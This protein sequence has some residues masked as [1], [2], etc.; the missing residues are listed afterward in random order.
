[1]KKLPSISKASHVNKM[2]FYFEVIIWFIHIYLLLTLL[3][4]VFTG[5][6]SCFP[7]KLFIWNS[8][9]NFL[10]IIVYIV[11]DRQTL[12]RFSYYL[13]TLLFVYIVCLLYLYIILIPQFENKW[14]QSGPTIVDFEGCLTPFLRN[15]LNPLPRI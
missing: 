8:N 2:N 11:H 6:Q 13:F 7:L 10:F 1:M 14:I 12:D 15:H 3:L 4:R 5:T 9:Y